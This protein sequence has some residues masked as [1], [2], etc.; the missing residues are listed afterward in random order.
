[1]ALRQDKF[2][3]LDIGPFRLV[4]ATRAIEG[5]QVDPNIRTLG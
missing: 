3:P 4:F 1:M 2:S 5:A